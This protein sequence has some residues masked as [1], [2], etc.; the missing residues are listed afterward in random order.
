MT[1]ECEEYTKRRT[2]AYMKY[3]RI[4]ASTATT[5]LQSGVE[6]RKRSSVF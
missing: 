6:F 2:A 3:V 4:R 5:Q 1:S